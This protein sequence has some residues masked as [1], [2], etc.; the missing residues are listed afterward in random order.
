MDEVDFT[1][2]ILA[3]KPCLPV[4]CPSACLNGGYGYC[5]ECTQ[6]AHDAI[7]EA[8]G[9]QMPPRIEVH[10]YYLD[11]LAAEAHHLAMQEIL[12]GQEWLRQAILQKLVA[13]DQADTT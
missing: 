12:A 9:P 13:E 4:P 3:L 8:A 11:G 10:P 2:S 6:D 7:R 1:R 5:R